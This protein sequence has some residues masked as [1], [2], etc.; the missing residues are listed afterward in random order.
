MNEILVKPITT[1][2]TQFHSPF[3]VSLIL[4]DLQL[5]LL[6]ILYVRLYIEEFLVSFYNSA[7][8][9]I[10]NSLLTFSIE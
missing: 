6:T 1:C 8:I 4:D 2:L 5:F 3:H 10:P 9:K 7:L